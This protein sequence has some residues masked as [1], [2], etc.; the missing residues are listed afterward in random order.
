VT[1]RNTILI[2]DATER[3]REL[4]PASV[5][6][7]IT[8]P[9]YF[10]LRDY[11]AQGQIG[12]ER[13]VDDWVAALRRVM[14]AATGAL[15]PAG[16]AWLVVSDTYARHP[17]QGALPKSL[18]FGP[19]R[20]ALALIADGWI[21]RNKIVWAK[22]NPMPQSVGDRLTNTYE[23]VYVL[24]RQRSYFF[25]LDAI[26]TAHRT[27]AAQ[28]PRL[29]PSERQ[30]WR[31]PFSSTN[32]RGKNPGDV[33][34]VAVRAVRGHHATF[35]ERLVEPAVLAG[36]PARVCLGCGTGWRS[37]GPGT[38]PV[39]ACACAAATR[40]G[41]VL[42]PFMGSGTV[43]LV[44]ER[45]GRDWLGIELNPAYAALA[46]RRVRAARTTGLRR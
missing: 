11:G 44:A 18:L 6:C 31:G 1:P 30:D 24:T 38:V 3:L 37:E 25:D 23:V 10:L 33:W 35:P 5:D 40:P 17:N 39:P 26:R 2:G 45:H 15:A 14:R 29:A 7:L 43:G 16:S 13:S 22:P 42:D 41:L 34:T 21:V 12:L 4:P 9:P 46:E 8:S 32:P 19:E 28:A 20:L 36:C 27:A